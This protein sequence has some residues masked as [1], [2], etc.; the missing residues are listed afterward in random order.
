MEIDIDINSM[1][2]LTK[3][4]NTQ[5]VLGPSQ[6]LPPPILSMIRQRIQ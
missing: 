1:D 4:Y 2:M 6:I 5:K 3:S